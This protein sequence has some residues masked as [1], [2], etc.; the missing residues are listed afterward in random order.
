MEKMHYSGKFTKILRHF[1]VQYNC[2]TVC[3]SNTETSQHLLPAWT[4]SSAQRPG[5]QTELTHLPTS[6]SPSQ[7]RRAAVSRQTLIYR[8]AKGASVLKKNTCT[9]CFSTAEFPFMKAAYYFL[10]LTTRTIKCSEQQDLIKFIQCSGTIHNLLYIL[11]RTFFKVIRNTAELPT[12]CLL[13]KII[14]KTNLKSKVLQ[15]ALV[16][17]HVS[18]KATGLPSLLPWV[19]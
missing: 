13:L 16:I 17:T 3:Q 10:W 1:S 11:A 5:T 12:V 6:P 2:S 4:I 7:N 19:S 9:V 18:S 14:L 8:A 15:W